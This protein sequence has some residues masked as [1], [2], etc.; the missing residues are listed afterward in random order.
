VSFGGEIYEK[1][2]KGENVTKKEERGKK[3]ENLKLNCFNKCK[4]GKN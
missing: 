4:I 2:R 1:K 3:R